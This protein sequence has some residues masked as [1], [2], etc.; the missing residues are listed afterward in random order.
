MDVAGYVVVYAIACVC[1]YV[2][3]EFCACLCFY[4]LAIC[5]LTHVCMKLNVWLIAFVFVCLCV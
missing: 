1:I 2:W 5:L 4:V 3:V